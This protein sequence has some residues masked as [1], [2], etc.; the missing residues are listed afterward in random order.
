M[1]RDFTEYGKW[2]AFHLTMQQEM[3][4][5]RKAK[6]INDA[7]AL[8]DTNPTDA[9]SITAY[10]T[11]LWKAWQM[12]FRFEKNSINYGK[13]NKFNKPVSFI[14]ETCQLDTQHCFEHRKSIAD[15]K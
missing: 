15:V 6:A 14:P 9:A 13:C 12:E 11:L 8:L 4:G 2:E 1:E 7:Q 3:F 10:N 5:A